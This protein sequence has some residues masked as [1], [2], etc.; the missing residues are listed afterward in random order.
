ME[1]YR[2]FLNNIHYRNNSYYSWS[3]GL[4]TY[5]VKEGCGVLL[6]RTGETLLE[7]EMHDDAAHSY[8]E[9]VLYRFLQVAEEVT[10]GWIH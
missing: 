7:F 1:A 4:I 10:D 9:R 6:L 8:V 2:C 5:S 3:G